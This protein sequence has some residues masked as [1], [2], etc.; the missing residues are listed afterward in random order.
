MTSENKTGCVQTILRCNPIGWLQI[1]EGV[2]KQL[3]SS[4]LFSEESMPK[5]VKRGSLVEFYIDEI[6]NSLI[7][8][9]GIKPIKS[10]QKERVY[11]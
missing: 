5:G 10:V 7:F 2:T 11:K 4:T 9:E 3:Y 8:T 6:R 1:R